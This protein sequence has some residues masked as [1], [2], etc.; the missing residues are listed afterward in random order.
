[1]GVETLLARLDRVKKTGQGR[2]IARC[3]AH[4]DRGPSLSI[5]ELP[6]GRILVHDFAGCDV[7][8]VV[9]AVG[10]TLGDLFPDE[11]IQSA[12]RLRGPFSAMDALACLAA[13]SRII[14]F[15]ASDIVEGKPLTAE[16]ADR[17]A[18]AAGRIATAL[19]AVHARRRH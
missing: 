5:R 6:D 13:E 18:V 17:V 3:P 15:A 4:E 16:D 12:E 1:M 9:A 10:L 2:W 7:H 8:S 11:P 19:E 14:A